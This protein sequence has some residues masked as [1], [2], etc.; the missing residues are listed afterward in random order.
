MVINKIEQEHRFAV[1]QTC[2]VIKVNKVSILF[3][4]FE[5]IFLHIVHT[6]YTYTF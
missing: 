6:D 2:D 4:W 3:L 1:T 5:V